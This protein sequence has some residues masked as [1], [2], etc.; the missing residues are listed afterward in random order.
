MSIIVNTRNEAEEQVLM[1]F[2]DR[3]KYVYHLA[4]QEDE[5]SLHREFLQT[6]NQ[7]LDDAVAAIENGS[8]VSHQDV[9][10]LFSER[11]KSLE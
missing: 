1:A 4:E 6:Y 8:F 5:T 7:E 10:K 2:L 9:E 3:L 11:R